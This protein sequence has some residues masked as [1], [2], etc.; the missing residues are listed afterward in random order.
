M[1]GFMERKKEKNFS[2][3]FGGKRTVYNNVLRGKIGNCTDIRE[4]RMYCCYLLI[5]WCR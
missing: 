2:V 5:L 3:I 4:E 1:N